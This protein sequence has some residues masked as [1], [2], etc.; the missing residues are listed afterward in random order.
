MHILLVTAGYPHPPEAVPHPS[1]I[2]VRFLYH[3]LLTP[4]CV[5]ARRAQHF[6]L[7]VCMHACLRA[8]VHACVCACMHTY[9]YVCVCFP[10][11]L[12]VCLSIAPPLL[13]SQHLI[14]LMQTYQH[15][16]DV[17]IFYTML[18]YYAYAGTFCILFAYY[19]VY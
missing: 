12:S 13:S 15:T 1:T 8:C 17:K 7:C 11:C 3:H 16:V 4:H 2:K 9:V 10:V 6:A 18:T 14:L 5:G 19:V